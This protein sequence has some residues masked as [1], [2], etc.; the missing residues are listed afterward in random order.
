MPCARAGW[1]PR[2]LMP[3]RSLLTLASLVAACA[4]STTGTPGASSS[5]ASS[6][7]SA[8]SGVPGAA[9]TSVLGPVAAEG[10]VEVRVVDV[11]QGDGI[12]LRGPSG[13]VAVMDAGHG[14]GG[15]KI[16]EE[17][18]RM[19][20]R[21][22]D[23]AILS[24]AHLDHLGGFLRLMDKVDIV[25]VVDPAFPHAGKTYHR[26]LKQ[27][28]ARGVRYTVARRGME[29]P[30]GGGAQLVLLAPEEP[31]FHGTRSDANA[32]TIVAR[33]DYGDICMVLTGD[34]E[35]PTEDRVLD[36]REPIRCPILKVAHHGSR[37]STSERWLD[38]VRPELAVIS[39]GR[40]NRYGH[41]SPETLRRLEA[42]GARIYRTDLHGTV[43]LRTDGKRV[44]V[45]T[46]HDP[47]AAPAAQAAE[48][49]G[50][51]AP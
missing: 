49:A 3:V 35:L 9:E 40:K 20:S 7:A 15:L 50:A 24:H 31:L 39:A 5:H 46:T 34:A 22:I 2:R 32:N 13:V 28:E 11:G 38:G 1:Y 41:P 29:I 33:L 42:V 19:G 21:R 6:H 14:S 4:T 25:E 45:V 37:H 44:T 18:R 23:F 27:V 16:A 47:K 51:G 26:F 17:L 48:A 10:V 36:S 8:S 43:S 30:L 12:I